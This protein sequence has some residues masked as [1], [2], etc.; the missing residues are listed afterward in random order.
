MPNSVNDQQ[1]LLIRS[2]IGG[3]SVPLQLYLSSRKFAQRIRATY[4]GFVC[5]YYRQT[6]V[7]YLSSR[8]RHLNDNDMM[9]RLQSAYRRHHSIK[10]ALVKVL[11]NIYA[12]VDEQQVTL[13]GLLDLSAAFA[14]SQEPENS[15]GVVSQV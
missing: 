12:A 10:T 5:N 2:L 15:T 8:A 13:L 3:D 14:W 9:P 1:M 7:N 6:M 4:V 11:S